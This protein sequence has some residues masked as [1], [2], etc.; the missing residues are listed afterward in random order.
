[1]KDFMI[2][3]AILGTLAFPVVQCTYDN[4]VKYKVAT[5]ADKVGNK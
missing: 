3:L 4:W 1:M 2:T 5:A